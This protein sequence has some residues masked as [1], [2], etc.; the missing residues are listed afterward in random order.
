MAIK[1]GDTS[2]KPAEPEQLFDRIHIDKLVFKQARKTNPEAMIDIVCC[3]YGFDVNQEKKFDDLTLRGRTEDFNNIAI[4]E[5]VL[6]GKTIAEALTEYAQVKAQVNAKH[7]TDP[8]S[9]FELMAYFELA[10]GMLVDKLGIS[11]FEEIE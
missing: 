3:R 6:N 9:T 8:L 10:L 1:V 5:Q 2:T 7:L 11:K 4:G